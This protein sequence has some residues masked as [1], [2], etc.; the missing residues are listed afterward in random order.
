MLARQY[1]KMQ[2]LYDSDTEQFFIFRDKSP[3]KPQHVRDTLRCL[4][5]KIN[6]DPSLYNILSMRARRACDLIKMGFTIEEVKVMGRWRSNTI[7][8]Y[9]KDFWSPTLITF[10]SFANYIPGLDHIWVI[11]DEFSSNSCEEYFKRSCNTTLRG[12]KETG[13]HCSDN[14]EIKVFT[15]NSYLGHIKD[16]LGRLTNTLANALNKENI[17]HK[18]IVVVLD[19]DLIKYATSIDLAY[20]CCTENLYIT[21]FL[22]LINWYWLVAKKSLQAGI[23]PHPMDHSTISH[24]FSRQSSMLKNW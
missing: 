6:L 11:G 12:K 2:G 17:L 15:N 23:P 21:Y 16:F 5:S 19:N 8:K 1:M 4:I 3:L 24:Q 18:A 14:F 10:K 20:L 7:Y 13:T 9:L 22:N